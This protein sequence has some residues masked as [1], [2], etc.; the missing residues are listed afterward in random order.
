MKS[1][2]SVFLF[3]ISFV[4]YSQESIQNSLFSSITSGGSISEEVLSKRSAVLYNYTL[5]PT[6]LQTIHDNFIRTGID[7]VIYFDI[8]VALAGNDAAKTY[9]AYLSKREISTVILVKKTLSGYELIVAP[10]ND[11]ERFIDISKPVWRKESN[12]LGD[13]LTSLYQDALAGNKKKNNLIIDFPETD[14]PLTIFNGRRSELAPF[15]LKVD[16]LA[17]IKFGNEAADNELEE[18]FKT[19]PLKYKLVDKSISESDL[20]RQ[21]FTYILCF[22]NTHGLAAKKVLEYQLTKSENAFV[23]VTYSNGNVHLKNIAADQPV[24]KYYVRHFDSGN[25]FLGTKWDA[26]TTW[27]QSLIN[28][29]QGLKVDF[30]IN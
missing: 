10:F 22:V 2:Y 13:I 19:Y 25:V 16:N 27:Q 26:D 8:D 4:S 21:G 30:K 15:D 11:T 12:S 17:V 5:T 20:R 18:I 28:F 24:F 14:L 1:Y 23:S 7:A 6:E 29:I 3:L 9:S